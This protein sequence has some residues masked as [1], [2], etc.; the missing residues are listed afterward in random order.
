MI[1]VWLLFSLLQPFLVVL[2]HTYMDT[3]R[4]DND[5]D[6][7]MS[8]AE[9]KNTKKLNR[10]KRFAL[11]YNPIIVISFIIIYWAAGLTH[12]NLLKM[13]A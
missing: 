8:A 9:I 12:G 13:Y 7:P 2:M 11:I 6:Q 4:P 1:D 5:S 10:T 3:L